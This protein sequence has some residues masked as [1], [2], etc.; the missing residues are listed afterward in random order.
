SENIRVPGSHVGLTHNP[1]VLY[2]LA[3]RLKVRPEKWQ[4]FSS[5]GWRERL[6]DNQACS[7]VIELAEEAA[8]LFE[9]IPA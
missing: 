3:D 4:A 7:K 1:A 6:F 9:P 2:V 8:D 5:R